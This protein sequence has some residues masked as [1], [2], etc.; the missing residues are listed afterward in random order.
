MTYESPRVH[1]APQKKNP[2][3]PRRRTRPSRLER[4]EGKKQRTVV[5]QGGG[6]WGG[7]GGGGGGVWLFVLGGG[8]CFWVW[9]VW[10]GV[11]SRLTSALQTPLNFLDPCDVIVWR[12]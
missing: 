2:R 10:L 9:V 6:G 1:P 8:V 12:R 7:G 5:A 4:G 11:G 3:N